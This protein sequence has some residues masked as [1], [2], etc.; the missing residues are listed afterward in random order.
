MR[1]V[2]RLALIHIGQ[3]TNDFNPVP[4]T[5]RDYQAFGVYEG[6]EILRR[7]GKLGQVGGYCKAVEESGRAIE[8]IPI[9]RAWAVAGG[10]IDR[11][12]FDFFQRRIAD[13][14]RAA[15][16]IDGLALQLHGACAAEHDDDVEGAQIALCREILGPDVP[17]VLQ[18][19]HHAN[20]T[21]KMVANATAITAHRTQPHDPFDTGLVGTRLLIRIA[22]GEVSPRMAFRKIPLLSHQEQFLTKQAP[23]K[24]WFDHA[25][26][27][28]S[29]PR[30]L[31]LAPCP[32]QP[33]LDVAEGGWSAIAVTDGDQALAEKLADESA[34]LAWSLREEFQHRVALPIDE[35]VRQADAATRGVVVLSDTGDTVFGGSTG[36]SNLILE[37]ML[38]LGIKGPALVPLIEPPT[39]ARLF[40]AGEGATVTLPVGGAAATKFFTPLSVTGTVR[41]LADGK[42]RV[43]DNHQPDV[44]MGRTALF[45]VG[46]VL[47]LVS[48]LRGLAGNHPDVYRAFGIEPADY[49]MA[50]VKTASNFQYFAPVTSRMI[51]VDTRGPGQSD[52]YTL[53]WQRLPRPIYPLE[54]IADRRLGGGAGPLKAGQSDKQGELTA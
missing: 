39:V 13:G 18:L 1:G 19:D 33:W 11:D 21:R 32:M 2:L 26:A 24:T 6:E 27:A 10:R 16:K 40:A 25:R 22:A 49:R 15:G 31:Q 9:I 4:T 54:D 20:V 45:Q 46:P 3:E 53:P 41:K 52:V 14:L 17:I 35:A 37:A 50:V 34:D 42:I 47:L 23:M 44:D 29:D 12:A 30:V 7:L 38:R 28:E 43:T 36:D 5:L 8:T 48:E 51:R